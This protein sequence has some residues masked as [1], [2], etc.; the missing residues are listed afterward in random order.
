MYQETTHPFVVAQAGGD[1]KANF[2]RKTY[3]HL[4][5]AVLAFIGLEIALFSSPLAAKIASL[6]LNSGSIGWLG[7]LGVFIIAGWLARSM[8]V[9]GSK[10]TQYAGLG[11]YVVAE[12]L[13]FV[14]ILYLAVYYSSPQV[15]TNAVIMTLTL[16]A[17]LTATVFIT[18]TDFSFL[19]TALTVGGFIAIGAIVCG[20]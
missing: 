3:M 16:F 5:G 17:G 13:I 1:V 15:L 12:A 19:K 10:T 9:S 6:V 18:R 14:P 8:A 4:A 20:A 2:I 7:F 11:F